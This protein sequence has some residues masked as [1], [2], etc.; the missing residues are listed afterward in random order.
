M[1]TLLLHD[2]WVHLY[3][4][5]FGALVIVNLICATNPRS[6]LLPRTESTSVKT[7]S[8]DE[9]RIK[10]LDLDPPQRSGGVEAKSLGVRNGFWRQS[11][12]VG[13]D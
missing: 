3:L 10:G 11:A 2:P 6:K 9:S 1:R 13:R 8:E 7:K 5:F 4:L 12:N